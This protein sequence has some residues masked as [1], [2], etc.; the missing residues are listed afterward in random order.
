MLVQNEVGPHRKRWDRTG[1]VVEAKPH[2]Q[3]LIKTHG[4]GRVTL[5]NPAIYDKLRD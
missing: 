2:G 1:V 5:R 4:S 3:Y